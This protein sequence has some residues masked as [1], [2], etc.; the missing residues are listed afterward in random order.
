MAQ[1][2]QD[3]HPDSKSAEQN[4]PVPDHGYKRAE[5]NTP[6]CH[7]VKKNGNVSGNTLRNFR[8]VR[9]NPFA[10]FRIYLKTILDF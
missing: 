8:N 1:R 3:G 5:Q 6:V 7:F 2:E 4:T 10:E 9:E